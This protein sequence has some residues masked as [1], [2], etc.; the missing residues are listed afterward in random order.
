[1]LTL[2]ILQRAHIF[3]VICSLRVHNAQLKVSITNFEIDDEC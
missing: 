3:K 2:E 1:M